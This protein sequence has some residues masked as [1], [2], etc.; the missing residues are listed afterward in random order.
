MRDF[1]WGLVV[2]LIV[3]FVFVATVVRISAI[4]V[5]VKESQQEDCQP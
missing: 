1:L 5:D 3:A 4:V 2:A